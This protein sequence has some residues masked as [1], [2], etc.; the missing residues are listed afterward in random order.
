MQINNSSSPQPLFVG[1]IIFLV[2]NREWVVGD[3]VVVNLLIYIEIYK[4]NFQTLFI[5]T[6]CIEVSE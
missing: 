4:S 5:F 2:V 3:L 1:L 6:E